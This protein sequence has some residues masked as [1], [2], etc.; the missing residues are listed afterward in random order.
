MDPLPGAEASR[1]VGHRLAN[2]MRMG[3]G[4]GIPQKE[5]E[6]PPEISHTR[7]FGMTVTFLDDIR[8]RVHQCAGREMGTTGVEEVTMMNLIEHRR[9]S[10]G[11]MTDSV[12]CCPPSTFSP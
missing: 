6:A 7:T 8:D 5:G 4:I 11:I 1:D 2:V 3:T 10:G 12:R 9:E